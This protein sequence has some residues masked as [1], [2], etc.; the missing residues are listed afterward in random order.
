MSY[1]GGQNGSGHYHKLIN[2]IPKKQLYIEAFMGMS[3][4]YTN[5]QLPFNSIFYGLDLEKTV[6]DYWNNNNLL[7]ENH[8]VLKCD[9]TGT[10]VII[11]THKH[12]DAF[13]HFD[14]PYRGTSSP[15]KY[16]HD[17]ANDNGYKD[18]LQFVKDID[19]IN[20]V[21]RIGVNNYASCGNMET[22]T[23]ANLDKNNYVG[24]KICI[25]VSHWKDDLFD[26]YLDKF[27][28]I[29][30][31]TMSRGGVIDNGCYINYNPQLITLAD[32]SYSGI[33]FTQRQAIKRKVDRNIA[34]FENF[35]DL[36]KE[37]YLREL[38]KII[39]RYPHS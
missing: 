33:N 20:Y 21:D 11:D 38:N 36:E 15:K 5:I 30:F 7:D 14:P 35:S 39:R 9:Y 31:K 17:F 6:V 23:M 12:L 24:P 25:M 1:Y 34:K 16:K 4:I 10:N 27:K 2:L 19:S 37:M 32:Y 13:L 26:T 8:K 22:P 18:F 3:G 29:P 28:H